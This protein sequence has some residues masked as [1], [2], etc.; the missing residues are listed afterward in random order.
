MADPFQPKFVDLV[1]NTSTSVGTGNFTLGAAVTGYTS[2]TAAL[3]VGDQFYYSIIGIDKPGEHEVGRGTLL[4][5]GMMSRSA[6]GGAN[7]NFTSGTK[8]VALIAA[9]EWYQAAQQLMNNVSAYGQALASAPTAG[10][11]RA[12]LGL[13]SAAVESVS[14]FPVTIPDRASLAAYSASSTA[15]LREAGREGLFVWDAGNRTAEVAADP[16]QGI[17]VAGAGNAT[18]AAGSW[19]RKYSGP[20]SVR[21]FGALG[22]GVSDDGAA[23]TAAIALLKSLAGNTNGF[24]KASGKLI[25]PPGHYFLGTTTLDITHT[26]IVEGDG[27][28]FGGVPYAAK[29]RWA[30]G[31]TGIRVQAYD[32]S[33]AASV[34]N[35]NL[36]FSGAGSVIRG[37]HLYGGYAGAEG[38]HHGIQAKVRVGVED[39]LIEN[40]GG[41][42]VYAHCSAGSGGADEGNANNCRLVGVVGTG[43]RDG[44][45]ID[46]A[47]TNIWTVIGCDFSLNRRWGY[48]D[49]SFLGNSYFGCHADSNGLVPGSVAT[50]V[51]YSGNRYCARVGG[52]WSN[53]PSGTAADTAD[54]YYMGAGG[55][56]SGANIAAWSSGGAY[57]AGG[58]Y[59]TDASGNANN[60]FAG[61]YHESGQGFAQIFMPS[62]VSGGSMRP[63][64]RGVGV[65]YGAGGSGGGIGVAGGLS[66]SGAT[67]LDASSI[68]L[69]PQSGVSDLVMT[70]NGTGTG[71][72]LWF[73]RPGVAV[74]GYLQ[75]VNGAAYWNALGGYH[76]RVGGSEVA[77]IGATGIG[78]AAGAGGSV[79]Q[80]TSKSTG[81]TLNK[82]CGAITLS[83]ASLP[84]SAVASFT[85]SNSAIAADD[86][87]DVWLKAGAATAGTYRCWSEGNAAGSRTICLQNISGGALGEAVV[88]GFGVNKR[89][90]A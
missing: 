59:T 51:T 7:T 14:R 9:A 57:R 5:G 19:V 28:G 80:S 15:Y 64:V 46:G 6:S 41:D 38:E 82:V 86:Y 72:Q 32:T 3:Q 53:A 49:S 11:A 22:D 71:P 8:S 74:D 73:Q 42:A 13:G 90:A 88:L 89:V 68:S 63:F 29:L 76:L 85:L 44:L 10:A 4:G 17:Y 20:V 87:V 81:V 26:L 2:L 50:V 23:F 31:T 48:N 79:T 24:Y 37:L 30:A 47:D 1:R 27:T 78:Y 39:C 75:Y 21:W 65:L 58:S 12:S 62:L 55:A 67:N 69:G 60:L 61:C 25:V 35:A 83:G 84:A 34:D 18:G 36:H 52:S 66:V 56:Q 40:F 43:N 54:W 70:L 77:T 16:A 33:G 45:S